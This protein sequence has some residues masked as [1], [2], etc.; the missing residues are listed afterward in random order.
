MSFSG[1]KPRK[2]FGQHWL[3]SESVLKAILKAA[4]IVSGDRVLEVGPGR[5]ALTEKLIESKASVI[6]AIE[7]D[8][9]LA[10]GLKKKFGHDERFRLIEGDI[11]KTSTTSIDGIE[12][13]KVVANIPYNITGPLLRRLIGDLSTMP[14]VQYDSLVLLLQKEVAER[15]TANAGQSYFSALSVR[16]QLLARCEKVCDV[17]PKCFKPSPRVD[18]QVLLLKP[19]TKEDRINAELGNHLETLLRKAFLGRRK[20]LRNTIGRF[21]SSFVSIESLLDNNG[22]S[23]DKRPQDLS[24][25]Q[26]L[27]LA[28]GTFQ[29]F[30]EKEYVKSK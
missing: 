4:D 6:H 12:D 23:L 5:G 15:I 20:K 24:P 14:E 17:S 1:H 11:L 29:L 3:I 9:D 18:S 10:Y 21:L 2:R 28:K 26:W 25:L 16:V 27:A 22:I 19:L 30:D 7:L 13:N 8:R